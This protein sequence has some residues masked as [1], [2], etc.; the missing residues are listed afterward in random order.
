[1]SARGA[2]TI[3]IPRPLAIYVDEVK[4]P[5]PS[6]A[7]DAPWFQEPGAIHPGLRLPNQTS[8]QVRVGS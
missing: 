2:G 7:I 4:S 5:G 8:L 6:W 3:L 1:M